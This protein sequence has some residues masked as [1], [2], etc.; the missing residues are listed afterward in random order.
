MIDEDDRF[1]FE[2]QKHKMKEIWDN[3]E[4]DKWDS[5][6]INNSLK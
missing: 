3:K 1:V 6:D 2:I 5:L 4:D